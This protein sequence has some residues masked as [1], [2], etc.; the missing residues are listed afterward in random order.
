MGRWTNETGLVGAMT[1]A[2]KKA[3]PNAWIFNV[4]GGTY[5]MAGVPDLLVVVDGLTIGIEAKHQ[6][7]GESEQH[8]RERATPVQRVQIAAMNRAGAVAGVAITPEEALDLIA[9]AFK[10]QEVVRANRLASKQEK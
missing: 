1:K 8:A 6:K 4:H 9:R 2:I 3:Y 7:P 10:K 5:Q